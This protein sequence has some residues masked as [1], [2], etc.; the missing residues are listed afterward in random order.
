MTST[1]ETLTVSEAARILGVCRNV[2]YRLAR[3]GVIP[4]L[5]LGRRV[6]VP[7]AALARMLEEPGA[8]TE[9]SREQKAVARR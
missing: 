4:T 6:L 3:Q 2:A 7:R 1:R 5:R 9:M 8:A